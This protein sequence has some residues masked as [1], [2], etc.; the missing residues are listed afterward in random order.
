[1]LH[2]EIELRLHHQ[3]VARAEE[4]RRH[5]HPVPR[6]RPPGRLRRALGRRLV[7][8]GERVAGPAPPA[9][10]RPQRAAAVHATRGR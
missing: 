4:A 10:R 7:R 5:R 9:T 8:L 1:M 3:R 2:P 6:A